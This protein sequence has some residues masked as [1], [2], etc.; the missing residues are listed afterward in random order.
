M[1][2]LGAVLLVAIGLG[3]GLWLGFNPRAHQATVQ[4][5][6]RVNMAVTQFKTRATFKMPV[7]KPQ[8][9]TV[10]PAPSVQVSASSTWKQ[11]SAV[12]QTLWGSMQRLW[13]NVTARIGSTR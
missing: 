10:K 12:L 3:V 11:V 6:D 8:A 7:L 13:V 4:N 9:S 5:W 2:K 1:S